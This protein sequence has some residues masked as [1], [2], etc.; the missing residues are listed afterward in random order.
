LFYIF[1]L[2]FLKVEYMSY[3]HYYIY[4]IIAI[5]LGFI[6]MAITH[7]YLKSKGEE[8]SDLDKKIEYWKGRFEFVFVILMSLLLIYLFNPRY[9]NQVV[10]DYDMKLLLYLFGFILI[11][12]AKWS[13]FFEE[14][15]WFKRL[16]EVV[17][18]LN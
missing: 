17:G 14:A 10:I 8:H 9:N 16:Q 5:K 18:K 3:L 2:L 12:T 7:I 1:A 13:A 15:P 6:L 4:L 11:I